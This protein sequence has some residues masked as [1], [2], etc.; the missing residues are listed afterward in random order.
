MDYQPLKNVRIVDLTWA[1]VGPYS[2]VLLASMGAQ[3]IK[4]GSKMQSGGMPVARAIEVHPQLNHSKYSISIDFNDPR[5][6]DVVRRLVSISDVV[7]ENFRPGTL[8]KFGLQYKDLLDTRPDII[9]VSASLLGQTGRE[10]KYAAFAPVFAAMSGVSAVTGLPNGIPTEM[11]I[12]LDLTIGS[13]MAQA[14]LIALHHRMRTGEGQY[15]D[16]SGRDVLAC[17]IGDSI[18]E[19]AVNGRDR[20]LMGNKDEFWAPH[21]AYPCKEH[22]SWITISITSNQ[23]W[24]ALCEV[25]GRADLA[26]DP[27]FANSTLRRQHTET[28]DS[29]IANWTC[30]KTPQH[31]TTVLQS[32]GVP[33][34]PSY[35][36]QDIFDD[37]HLKERNYFHYFERPDSQVHT[38]MGSPWM[39][40]GIRPPVS[41]DAPVLGDD[42]PLILNDLIGL[43]PSETEELTAAGI[44]Q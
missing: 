42:N 32:A 11:G 31:L 12:Y 20:P 15:V 34:F 21:Q 8:A 29:E 39:I 10:S 36:P 25:M 27:Q 33:S 13:V 19:A 43:S 18:M 24:L 41:H 35:S 9:M 16:L 5:G 30:L 22:D 3:V 2:T 44:L 1:A 38:I 26:S 28:L 4:V 17:T 14:T 6:V 7:S 37:L 23:E 40:D